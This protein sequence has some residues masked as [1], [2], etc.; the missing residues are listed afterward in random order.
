MPVALDD[1]LTAAERDR[2]GAHL[3]ACAE[4]RGHLDDLRHVVV[5][6]DGAPDEPV[7]D[8]VRASLLQVFRAW[9]AGRSAG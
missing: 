6:M 3:L 7:S 4:C 5:A 9:H 2:V 1:A 8:E